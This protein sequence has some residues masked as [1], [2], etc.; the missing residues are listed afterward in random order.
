MYHI[1]RKPTK[2]TKAHFGNIS[3]VDIFCIIF[4]SA[5]LTPIALFRRT[6]QDMRCEYKI[7]TLAPGLGRSFTIL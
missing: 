3:T 2:G 1:P 7:R 5:S 6:A 4:L